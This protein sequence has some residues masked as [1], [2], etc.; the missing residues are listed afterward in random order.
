MS[1]S[2]VRTEIKSF[3]ASNLATENLI[4]LTGEF[5]ELQDL[6]ADHVPSLD[7][8]DNWLG[9]Q[10]IG[11]DETPITITS[12]NSRGC[13]RETGAIFLHIVEPATKL[14]PDAILVRDEIIRNAFRGQRINDIII[15]SATP[16]NF[17]AG[18][19]LQFEGGW[20]SASVVVNYYRDYNL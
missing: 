12:T 7:Y 13:Y 3:I 10:F 6:L 1:S 19:T 15:E 8:E 16:P 11:S 20:T 18:A 4:D 14:A 5:D 17:E 9:I 2:Y